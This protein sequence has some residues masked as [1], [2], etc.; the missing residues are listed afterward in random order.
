MQ[1]KPINQQRLSRDLASLPSSLNP[2]MVLPFLSAFWVTIAREWGS[3]EALRLDKYLYLIRQY[4]A[5]S[6]RYLSKENWGNT[7]EI[8]RYMS[9]LEETPLSPGDKKIPNGMRYHVLDVYVDELERVGGDKWEVETL[10]KLMG[11]VVRLQK[12]SRD[13]AIRKAAAE[14]LGDDRLKVWRGEIVEDAEMKEGSEDGEDE[15]AEWGGIED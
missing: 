6:F 9:I 11:P 3:I 14:T 2:S 7:E 1:D 10:E 8:E 13:K 15:D 4:V 12:E 5:A